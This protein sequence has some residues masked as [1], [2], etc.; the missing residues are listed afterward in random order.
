MLKVFEGHDNITS[1]VEFQMLLGVPRERIQ[2]K[3]IDHGFTV[4]FY[5]PFATNWKDAIRYLKRR[6][7]ENPHMAI[8][9]IKNIFGSVIQAFKRPH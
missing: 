9:T 6:L 7:E 8:Y 5:V 1:H 4:R 2:K 3:L